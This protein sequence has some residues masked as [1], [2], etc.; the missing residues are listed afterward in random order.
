[1]GDQSAASIGSISPS[2]GRKLCKGRPK[3]AAIVG[4]RLDS[5]CSTRAK[6]FRH[7]GIGNEEVYYSYEPRG[8]ELQGDSLAV[9]QKMG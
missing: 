8:E 9:L 5:V 6:I 4:T 3:V 1:L 2:A 7:S